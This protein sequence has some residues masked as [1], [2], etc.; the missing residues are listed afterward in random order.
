MAPTMWA[1]GFS[2]PPQLASNITRRWAGGMAF[3]RQELSAL[4]PEIRAFGS[5][6]LQLLN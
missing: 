6:D 2:F 3:R 4:L 1:V 5:S